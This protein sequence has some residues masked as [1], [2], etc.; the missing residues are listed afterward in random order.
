MNPAMPKMTLRTELEATKNTPK[1]IG[2]N[3]NKAVIGTLSRFGQKMRFCAPH[4]E[5]RRP[6]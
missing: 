3:T 1:N 2:V 4:F 6:S 5:Q